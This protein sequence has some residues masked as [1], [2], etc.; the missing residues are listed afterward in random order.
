MRSTRCLLLLACCCLALAALPATAAEPA[1]PIAA[2]AAAATEAPGACP[3]VLAGLPDP[4]QLAP[5]MVS[6]Q[7]SGGSSVACNGNSSCSTSGPNGRCVTCDGVQ[8][9]CC[10]LTACEQCDINYDNCI[11]TCD[12]KC[13]LC[14]NVYNHCRN[15]NNCN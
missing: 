13:N 4:I 15:F 5:C 9:G 8:Q 2:T 11:T 7:C 10:A 6:V 14:E 12:I 3:A 1:E